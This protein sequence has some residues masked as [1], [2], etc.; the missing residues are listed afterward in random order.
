MKDEHQ[1]AMEAHEWF[2]DDDAVRAVCLDGENCPTAC[3]EGCEVEPD[4]YCPHGYPAH[5]LVVAE[6][7]E[8]VID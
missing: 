6:D 2:E 1:I 4:G 7:W 5:F 8:W 3:P